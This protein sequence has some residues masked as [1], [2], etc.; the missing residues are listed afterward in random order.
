MSRVILG[1]FA[2]IV[3]RALEEDHGLV[4]PT[5]VQATAG[6]PRV[7]FEAGEIPLS[8]KPG[9]EH[10]PRPALVA[11]AAARYL[12]TRWAEGP[13]PRPVPLDSFVALDDAFP[14]VFEGG[15]ETPAGWH[16]LMWAGAEWLVE[17]GLP[18]GFETAQAKEKFGS[19][20][21]YWHCDTERDGRTA[22]VIRAV[23]AVSAGICEVCGGPGTLRKGGWA[24]TLCDE[25]AVRRG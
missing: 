7:V 10:K 23:E 14:H 15:T 8:P 12:A 17:T 22:G 16:F 21:W 6:G 19:L 9:F 2:H 24:R 25:H 4:R 18:K 13:L 20:R 5:G 3:R 1:E 11:E